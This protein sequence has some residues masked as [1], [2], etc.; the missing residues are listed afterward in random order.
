MVWEDQKHMKNQMIKNEAVYCHIMRV[1][2]NVKLKFQ[3]CFSVKF[4]D[5]F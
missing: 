5:V 4:R 2:V 1:D 3:S